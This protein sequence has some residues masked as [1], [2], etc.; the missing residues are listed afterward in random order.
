DHDEASSAPST[1]L[2]SSS[3]AVDGKG[4]GPCPPTPVVTD[5]LPAPSPPTSEE[6]PSSDVKEHP[7]IASAIIAAPTRPV[8]SYLWHGLST[9][10]VR[11]LCCNR[12]E[13]RGAYGAFLRGVD[14]N[15]DRPIEPVKDPQKNP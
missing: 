9:A 10:S 11:T 2:K 13:D 15:A 5:P 7:P 8:M 1:V 14:L 6:R 12:A 4:G 3:S